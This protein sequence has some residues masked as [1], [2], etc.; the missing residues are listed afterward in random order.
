MS[1]GLV[2]RMVRWG[3]LAALAWLVLPG[4][5]SAQYQ[6]CAT[7]APSYSVYT[8]AAHCQSH[9][10]PPAYKH[11]FEGPPRIHFHKGCPHP[12]CNPCDLPN[13]GYYE[14]C[15]TPWPF[16]PN[17][18]HCPQLPPAATVQ[19][20]P[21]VNPNLPPVMPRPGPGLPPGAAPMQLPPMPMP[22]MSGDPYETLPTPRPVQKN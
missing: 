18:A 15:W 17:W 13:W 3:G 8:G 10:C 5:A 20:N 21:Y 9:H 11:C 2:G 1:F 16:P 14:T 6:N 19:L 22:P 7:C 4:L 12:I